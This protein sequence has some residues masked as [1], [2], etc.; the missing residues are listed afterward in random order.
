MQL[1]LMKQQVVETDSK[2]RIFFN[3][4]LLLFKLQK[5]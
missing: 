2:Q 3:I 1:E 5:E 4:L